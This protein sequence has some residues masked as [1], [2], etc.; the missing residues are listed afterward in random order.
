M[1][2][3]PDLSAAA[4]RDALLR[5][6]GAQEGAPE[7][8]HEDGGPL[9]LSGE[10]LAIWTADQVDAASSA[11][12]ITRTWRIEGALDA[13]ALERALARL[14]DRHPVLRLMVRLE[15]GVPTPALA[16]PRQIPLQVEIAPR[17]PA[18]QE[19]WLDRRIRL[20]A[21]GRIDL[22][23]EPACRFRLFVLQPTL[24]ILGLSVHH[25]AFDDTSIGILA[26]EIGDLYAA[27]TGQA[28]PPP[29]AP[30]GPAPVAPPRAPAGTLPHRPLPWPVPGRLSQDAGRNLAVARR[31]TALLRADG[32]TLLAEIARSRG[33]TTYSLCAAA[34]AVLLGQFCHSRGVAVGVAYSIRRPE[35]D[36]RRIGMLIGYAGV[37]LDLDPGLG[38]AELGRTYQTEL[39]RIRAGDAAASAEGVCATFLRYNR[40][41]RP[42]ELPGLATSVR[43]L[44]E[45]SV[46][47]DLAAD[48]RETPEGLEFSFRTRVHLFT[49]AD[50]EA[51]LAAYMR[52]VHRLL[53]DP[54]LAVGDVDLTGADD[55][56]R[57]AA[58]ALNP[59]P[60]GC[61]RDDV[62]AAFAAAVAAHPG[63]A[64]LRAGEARS[65]YATLDARSRDLAAWLR[66]DLGLDEGMAVG[67]MLPR[68]EALPVATLAV[69][70]AGLVVVPIDP[71]YPDERIG[72][73][74]AASGC[75]VILCPDAAAAAAVATVAAA[76]GTGCRAVALPPTPVPGRPA[77]RLGDRS[78]ARPA[79]IV[80]TSGT[81][82]PAKGAVIPHAALTRLAF[83]SF[84]VRPGPGDGI[85]Q[86]ASPGFDGAFIEI[87][88]ALLNRAELICPPRTPATL[89]DFAEV[90]A[91][92]GCTIAFLSTALFNALADEDPGCFARLRQ[93]LVGGEALSRP[94]AERILAAHPGITLWNVYGPTEN[95]ALTTGGPI[96]REHGDAVSGPIGRPL[97]GNS[98][99]IVNAAMRAV[100]FGFAGE[101]L[102]GGPGL[103]LGYN[104]DPERT[105]RAFVTVRPEALGL[106]A[107]PALRLYRTGD[108]CRWRADGSAIDH[109]GRI[110]AQV[111]L[112]GY[113]I[114]PAEIEAALTALPG[115]R[116]AAVRA[117]CD[118][119]AGTV[120]A[121]EAFFET[122]ADAAAP[123][124]AALEAEARRG[125]SRRLPRQLM[126]GRLVH[127]PEGLPLTANGKID[128]RALD[129]LAARRRAQE[130]GG[131]TAARAADPRLARIWTDLLGPVGLGREAD[132]FTLGGH[133]L[134]ALRM[135]ARVER[136]LETTVEA[137]AFLR[138]PRMGVLED[139]VAAGRATAPAAAAARSA[140]SLVLRAG[141]PARPPLVCLP[142]LTGE[143]GWIAN[144]LP[145]LDPGGPSILGLRAPWT[146][147][148]PD[149]PADL[150]ALCGVFADTIAETIPPD[151]PFA[152]AGYSLS[153]YL[154]AALTAV[155]EDRGRPPAQV[156]M[157]DPGNTLVPRRRATTG[158]EQGT[159]RLDWLETL[160]R[161]HRARPFVTR[162]DFIW[163]TRGYPWPRLATPRDWS[164]L[165]RGGLAVWPVDM[166]HL[167][168]VQ[169][170]VAPQ[171]AQT[172]ERIIA[173]DGS[174][175]E[176]RQEAWT[177]AQL[178]AL[179]A[180]VAAAHG[181]DPSAAIPLFDALLRE[182]G[183]LPLVVDV[184]RLQILAEAGA[185][186]RLAREA[187]AMLLR[188]GRVDIGAWH[189]TA[190]ALDTAGLAWLGD[191]LIA[192]GHG[193]ARTVGRPGTGLQ[194]VARL[195]SRGRDAEAAGLAAL[196]DRDG[197]D[198][199]DALLAQAC[200]A[201]MTG[202]RGR[203][204]DLS[205]RALA[206]SETLLPHYEA[207]L[208]LVL[209]PQDD[210][211]A[212][213]LIDAA[214]ELW[215]GDPSIAGL[216]RLWAAKTSEAVPQ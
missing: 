157:V 93:L 200:V 82:G 212:L 95:G 56:G 2:D 54:D 6:H 97:P 113:R 32:A 146:A 52:L 139:A 100:P 182:T 24:C 13:A 109:L 190:H 174:P 99:V 88:G 67:I 125:L 210:A 5:R 58:A 158:E 111:K 76:G 170:A 19:A 78:P 64:A 123:T 203:A 91:S 181:P 30:T 90:V 11:F 16:D 168:A 150:E 22:A 74:V 131:D 197:P 193:G 73:I 143:P 80:F 96:G 214:E 156:I 79:C 140:L 117:V 138:D 84:P 107:G 206:R 118:G 106:P 127:L 75:R 142:G 38:L 36:R 152:I 185:R 116:A 104:Q 81:T 33:L 208:R 132:F 180:A 48:F 57:H 7:P 213:S 216:R 166:M 120:T 21:T 39:A 164:I 70:R 195:L 98:V 171:L 144:L 196:L 40:Y 202:Q 44:P 46:P 102:V 175:P 61:D 12:T 155:L 136:E 15:G 83:G 60:E 105:A 192:R 14:M 103:A 119:P 204:Y 167:E 169:R 71:D 151:R 29:P 126:P 114:E 49:D 9:S 31:S 189:V 26:A 186:A 191:R 17:D 43:R 135:L 110:D 141:N 124:S 201:R 153:G 148:S 129:G 211:F 198:R 68:G 28:G 160:R 177:D 62:P 1:T 101:L 94:H 66:E 87:W 25:I 130:A 172:V 47:T 8:P 72:R 159:T 69:L 199:V 63:A 65:D 86:L 207:V 194:R 92:P 45:E 122:E 89:Q 145:F 178:D 77:P 10:Q 4:L 179:H 41:E 154:A 35:A 27:E 184:E 162:A 147:A 137:A 37:S 188:P 20:H 187:A 34:F 112:N 176:Q 133:S 85:V 108:L 128:R 134:L 23:A 205:A 149:R 121:L 55:T 209:V 53:A 215:R 165:A 3:A 51:L 173:G 42:P 59:A 18:Q 50:R 115:V 163:C 161:A 183:A